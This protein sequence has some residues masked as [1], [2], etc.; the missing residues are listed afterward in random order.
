MYCSLLPLFTTPSVCD[1]NYPVNHFLST[2]VAVMLEKKRTNT[3][4]LLSL[5]EAWSAISQYRDVT[6]DIMM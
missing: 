1:Y 6:C 5:P 3:F 4:V 2:W